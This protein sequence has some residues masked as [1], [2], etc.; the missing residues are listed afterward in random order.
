MNENW[1]V[2][3]GLE[4]HCQLDTK[5]KI[6]AS[7][8]ARFGGS[9]NTHI[10]PVTLGLPGALPVL[11]ESVLEKAVM[12]GLALGCAIT[13]FT[14]FDRKNYFYPDLPKGYQISQFDRPYATGGGVPFLQK[15]SG[16]EITIPLTRIHMEEDAGKLIHS[17]DPK[18]NQSYVDFNR[19]GTPLIEIV[20]EPDLRSSEDAYAYLVALKSILRYVRVS[21][22]NMEEGS[23]RCDANV[24]VRPKGESKFRTRV[25]IKNLNSFKAVKDAIDYEVEWQIDQYNQNKTFVQMTKLWDA[26]AK[27]TVPMRTKEMSHDYRYFP[28]PD[29]PAF[30]ITPK[31]ISAIQDKLPELPSKRKER[32]KTALGLPEYDAGVLTSEREIAEYY[33]E[34]V[35]IC[36][37]PKK[38]SNWVKDEILGIVNK[39]NVEIT[40]F[41]IEPKRMGE[42]IS[43]INAGEISGKIAKTI[44]EEMLNSKDS[45]AKIVEAKGLKVV[46]DDKA[47][48]EIVD[49]VMSSM[50]DA[51]ASWKQGK[52][53]ALGSLVG[54]VMKETKGKADPALVNKLLLEKLG[55]LGS[56]S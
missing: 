38:A 23:L 7:G 22:C 2:V 18:V 9:P 11:N 48:E 5:S 44:F 45:P 17:N 20:S 15:S 42:L 10:D 51:I 55:P 3:I 24:S 32:Y 19:A 30:E 41:P 47:I 14:K 40:A 53:R 6:F 50:P 12:A 31:F 56:K 37:D 13:R 52:D 27:V 35:N 26:N 21:D 16:T 8:E 34:V 39:E 46:R 25:E 36:K 4:V 29:L 1:E 54:S 28:D 49:R 33:E 43:L